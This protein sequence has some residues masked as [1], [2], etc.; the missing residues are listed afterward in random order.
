MFENLSEKLQNAFK[1]IKGQTHITEHNVSNTIKD[2][3]KA[4]LDADV[5]YKIA[6]EFTEK[7]KEKAIG[8]KII[9][10]INP[11]QLMVKIMQDELTELMGSTAQ[12]LVLNKPI[13]VVLVVGLQ[14]NGK[15][16]FCGKLAMHLKNEKKHPL[17]VA[18]DVYR[19]AAIEQIKQ[20]AQ[21]AEVE[22]YSEDDNKNVIQIAQNAM[23]HAKLHNKNVLI[24]DTA[25]RLAIDEV[26]MNEV[27]ELKKAL[28]P[29]EILFVIDAM[30][31]QDAVNTAKTFNDRLDFSGVVLT[32]LDG[33]TRG[34]AALSVKYTVQKPIKFISQGEK[35]S[36]LD[37]FYPDRLAQRILGMGDIV[38]LVEK[39]EKQF[40]QEQA[41]KLD[42]K[43]RQNKFDYDDF[44]EQ[45]AQI[46]KMG[47]IKD[48]MSM[49]PGMGKLADDPNVND[50]ALD[51]TKAIILS[52]TPQERTNPDLMNPSRK[53]RIA[54]GCGKS[55]EEIN[56]FI[57]QFE[58]MKNMMKNMHKMPKMPGFNMPKF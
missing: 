45:L 13:S 55:I 40:T 8:Q 10:S 14:G 5:N 23:S 16:T 56:A 25:G 3:R 39:A 33:D 44:L 36:A 48:I 30:V 47:S 7:V 22:V 32:K 35:L 42:K 38:S 52:M 46:Q 26:M 15:T 29:T 2:I 17:L 9:Q 18:A 53:K 20:L 41:E 1:F 21:Q 11:G 51:K 34:G 31:G 43:I 28:A 57:K 19:P 6:K 27:A 58:Q 49:I 50:K 37:V 4:L 54:K 24:V 12:D